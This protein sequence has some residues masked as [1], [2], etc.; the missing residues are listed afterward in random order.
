[1][2]HLTWAAVAAVSAGLAGCGGGDIPFSGT[3]TYDGR[4]LKEGAVAFQ[5]DPAAGTTGPG[6]VVEVKD[7]AFAAT[8][9]KMLKPG[10]YAVLVSPPSYPSGTDPKAV[11]DFPIYRT[12]AEVNAG[13][14]LTICESV[15]GRILPG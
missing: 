15:R 10:T 14:I 13:S 12:T 9:E 6:A 1:M 4:P 8:G 11:V 2:R 3:V 5:A 7:G